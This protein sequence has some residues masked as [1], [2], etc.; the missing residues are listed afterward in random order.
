EDKSPITKIVNSITLSKEEEEKGSQYKVTTDDSYENIDKQSMDESV[1]E[2]ETENGA[3]N[4]PAEMEEE[5][6]TNKA[7]EKVLIK[8]EDKSPITKS[9]NSI[10]LSKEEE[11]KGS[12]Y[13]VTTDDS[14]E[15]IDKQSMD[16]SVKEAETENGAKNKPAEMEEV[17]DAHSSRPVEYY[18]KYRIKE[19]LINGLVTNY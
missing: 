6:I 18:L 16:E 1:K 15:N 3:K 4:K 8:E 12:Q 2:D 19:K 5:L 13:K 9:V 17:M 10:T 7:L 11:E 14:C